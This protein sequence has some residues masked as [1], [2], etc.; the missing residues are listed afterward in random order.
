MG[1][2][3]KDAL[4]TTII[5]YLGLILGY[6]NKGVLFLIFLSTEQIGLLSLI[7]SIGLL[8]AQF[9]NLGMSYTVWRFFPFLRNKEKHNFGFFQFSLII[10]FIGIVLF[11]ILSIVFKDYICSLYIEKSRQFVQY[12]YWMVPIG[13]SYA[14]F[15][16]F[17]VFL[18]GLH[19]NIISV[20][21]TELIMRLFVTGCIIIYAF[22]WINFF[23][24]LVLHSASFLLPTLILGYQLFRNKEL[25]WRFSDIAIPKRL[26]NIIFSYSLY[27][28]INFIGIMVVISIDTIMVASM[29]GLDATGVFSTIIYIVSGL[30][31]PYKSLVRISSPFVAKYW[32][33][34]DM[35]RMSDLYTRISSI[36]LVIGLVTFLVFW[37]NRLEIFHFLPPA[38][39]D[40]VYVFLILMIGRI[41][42]MYCGLN[43]VIFVT[44]K[45][46]KY[47]LIFTGFLLFGVYFLNLY[48]IPIYGIY[49]AAI[50]TT[51]AF[52]FYNIARL[53]FVYFAYSIHPFKYSQLVVIALFLAILMM[54]EFIP[55]LFGNELASMA[56]KLVTVSALFLFPIYWLKLDKDVVEYS[57]SIKGSLVKRLNR[58]PNK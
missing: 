18:R 20:I 12:Y 58:K 23:D 6:V 30:L 26:K 32:K 40:G 36:G 7:V 53:L 45:K 33:E 41:V 29:V 54:F 9:S 2:I 49:G 11:S 17:D 13:I 35:T 48:L 25:H 34:R 57:N 24:L 1:I 50:S 39:S 37:V 8:F 47:D 14:L 31:I 15:M 22:G 55:V 27:S 28:Y 4:K 42:D 56:I 10:T 52:V 43:G 46:Y 3:K 21:A 5:S 16:T 44:S 51:L 19:K 38:F